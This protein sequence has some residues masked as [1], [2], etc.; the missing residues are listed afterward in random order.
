MSIRPV[1]E[2]GGSRPPLVWHRA[3]PW[4]AAL[5]SGGL[6]LLGFAP[7]NQMWA[8]WVGLTPLI[9]AITR[10]ER[11]SGWKAAGLGY[12]AGVVFFTGTFYWLGTLADL[13]ESPL[14]LGIPFLLALLFGGYFAV[15]TWLLGSIFLRGE[16]ARRFPNSWMNLATGA[17]GASSWVM[18]EWVR[19]WLFGGFGWNGIGVALHRDLPLIQ[20]A[21]IT[22]VW[23]VSWLAVFVNLMIVIV[24]R[25]FIGEF[26]PVF[27]KRVRWE[28][29]ISVAIVVAAFSFGIRALFQQNTGPTVPLRIAAIQPNI[30]QKEK[31][32]PAFEDQVLATFDKLTGLAALTQPPPQ[33][34]I[35]P[36]A[37]TP[38]PLFADEN[39]RDFVIGQAARG[40]HALLLGTTDFEPTGEFYNI[41]ALFTKKGQ[42]WQY[43]RK[44]H[45]VP[46]GEYLPLRG[47]LGP[48]AGGLI[49]GDFTPGTEHT[50][51]HLREPA[52]ALGALVCFEDTV[53]DLTRKF[54]ANGAQLLVNVTNDGWFAQ[55]PAA[56]QHL[57]NAIFRAIET[58]R[59]LVRCGN[60][61]LT[62]SID[63]YGRVTHISG[64]NPA[65]R[66]KHLLP[67]LKP[68]EQGFLSGEIPVPTAGPTTFY[69]RHGDWL[70]KLGIFLTLLMFVPLVYRP[71]TRSATFKIP[72]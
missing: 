4:L 61:G 31:F 9:A 37:C 36:E 56:E 28:F 46:F 55:S 15:W 32:D 25:R 11:P 27:L 14:L 40:D 71:S 47:I 67:F 12:L 20:I 7:F 8:A 49:P 54:A 19:G 69:T 68:F 48:I 5:L 29:S 53:G 33:L 57:A 34:I 64:D 42:E 2:H 16:D 66:P 1:F 45:L 44:V 21:E 65:F 60:T 63:P 26:G 52:L 59:P 50:L 70:P 35:W 23:G 41:A 30:P 51:L 39:I 58:R 22:G 17:L 10:R 3:W 6:L 43:Y 18:L 24:I 38:R 72:T 62:G 13:Y